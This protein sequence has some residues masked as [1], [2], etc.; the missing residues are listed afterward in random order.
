MPSLTVRLRWTSSSRRSEG[1]GGSLGQGCDGSAS[2]A[3]VSFKITRPSVQAVATCAVISALGLRTL[4]INFLS[5]TLLTRCRVKK[6]KTGE[7]FDAQVVAAVEAKL[8]AMGVD[9][10]V[11]SGAETI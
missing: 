7:Q 9:D 1:H 6:P 8:R 3:I 5:T 2:S 4:F 10:E 11:S